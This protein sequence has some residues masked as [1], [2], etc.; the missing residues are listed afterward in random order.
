MENHERAEINNR[1]SLPWN[2]H[3]LRR[4]NDSRPGDGQLLER[5]ATDAGESAE[6]AF[7]VLVERH[8]P[9]VLRVC[10]SVLSDWHDTEDAFQATFLVL[11]QKARGLWVQDSLGPWLHQVAVRTASAA[12]SRQPVAA[13]VTNRQPPYEW[14][15]PAPPPIPKYSSACT[16]R[17]S[18]CRTGSGFRWSFVTSKHAA[19]SK[20]PGTSAGRSEPSRAAWRAVASSFATASP[21]AAYLPAQASSS[22]RPG[23]IHHSPFVC[24]AWSIPRHGPP[25]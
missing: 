17:S 7:A 3:A 4:G 14:K 6:L 25:S 15:M 1:K 16:K 20:P 18:G 12:R 10:H 2:P 11:V 13:A 23:T 5:F 24:P 21:A 8:G 9:M 22:P 19:I